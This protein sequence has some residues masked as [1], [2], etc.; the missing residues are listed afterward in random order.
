MSS[1]DLPDWPTVGARVAL[2]RRTLSLTQAALAER[3]GVHRSA[4]ARIESGSR[5][6][7]ALELAALARITDLPIDWFIGEAVP[8]LP[9][10]EPLISEIPASST[11]ESMCWH[12]R[13]CRCLSWTSSARRQQASVV[14]A[15]GCLRCRGS[16]NGGARP[17]RLR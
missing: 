4:I 15:G 10:G 3:I 8:S 12:V 5:Q 2:A 9:A 16:G 1:V 7:N 17:P 13:W 6:L 14:R 11:C